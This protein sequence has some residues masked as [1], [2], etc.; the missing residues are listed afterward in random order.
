MTL[1]PLVGRPVDIV[2]FVDGSERMGKENFVL[3]L[4]FIKDIAKEIRLAESDNDSHGARIAV[5]QY[6]DEN[7]QSVILDFSFNLTNIQTLPSKAVYY[8]SSSHV[9]MGILYAIKNIV[10]GQAGRH[11]GARKNA[12]VSFVFVTDG[13]NSNKNFAQAVD[14]LKENGIVTSAIAVGTDIN[15]ERL[16]QL[17]LKDSASLFRLQ[18]FDQLFTTTFLK[19]IVQWLG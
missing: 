13:M 4:R 2:F 18:M 3:V 8:E 14:S 15:I 1:G 10:Q 6:G 12:E 19:N 16:T 17:T 7:E 5:I 11:K 9:G